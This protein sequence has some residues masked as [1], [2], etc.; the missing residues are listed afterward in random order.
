MTAGEAA[1]L[2]Y[3]EDEEEDYQQDNLNMNE[4]STQQNQ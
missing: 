1:N 2:E 4:N 3:A